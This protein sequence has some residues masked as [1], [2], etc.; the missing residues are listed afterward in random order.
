[1]INIQ[2]NKR[3][4]SNI[5]KQGRFI[6][7]QQYNLSYLST[8]NENKINLNHQT[9]QKLVDTLRH[10][11]KQ[12][13]LLDNVEPTNSS[14]LYNI[15]EE[16]SA[17]NSKSGLY[18]RQI[19]M[20]EEQFNEAADLY[21]KQVQQLMKIGKGT[22][23]KFVQR[24]LI[25]WFEPMVEVI[26]NE[27][28]RILNKEYGVDRSHY[29]PCLLLIKPQ[30]LAVIT[31]ETALNTI[32][33][34]GNQGI[35][36]TM[37]ANTIGSLVQ[38]EVN[39]DKLNK[40]RKKLQPWH[41]EQLKL[42]KE[43]KQI[44]TLAKKVQKIVTDEDWDPSLKI[45]VG[46]AL[47]SLLKD[48]A[49]TNTGT[50]AF[51][52][53]IPY[54]PKVKPGQSIKRQGLIKL[55]QDLFNELSDQH[56]LSYSLPRY[57]PMLVKPKLWD[58]KQSNT[59]CYFRLKSSL[60]RSF[61]RDQQIALKLANM[62]GVLE[63]LNYL[64]GTPWVINN[65]VLD[66]VLELW[67]KGENIGE[68]P[69]RD[70]I[71]LPK[72]SDCY[73]FPNEWESSYKNKYK[74]NNETE[75]ID[76]TKP[77]EKEFDEKYYKEMTRRVKLKNSELHSIRCDTQLK[78]WIAEKFRE[79]TMYFPYNLDFRGRAYPIPPNLNHLG[80]DLCRGLL[81]FEQKK[82]L[83]KDGLKWLQIHLC[84]L[85]GNNK[86][87]HQER[88]D[89]T[90]ENMS[91]VI[92]SVKNPVNGDKWWSTFEEPY[93]ALSTCIEI[94]NAIESGDP[95]SYMCSLPVH[96]DGSCNGLQ[97]YA[98]L[99][100][101]ELGAKAV[102]LISHDKPQDVYTSVLK[103]ILKKISSDINIPETNSR[104][105][106]EYEALSKK[107]KA[108]SSNKFYDR[109]EI[110]NGKYAR[111][112]DGLIDRKVIKQTVMTSVYGVTRV[113]AREQVLARLEEKFSSDENMIMTPEIERELYGA[114]RYIANLTLFSLDEMFE[115]AK[116][117]MDWLSH[118]AQ[119]VARNGQVM[120][121]IT[122]LGLPV[123]QP[124]RKTQ[125][126]TIKTIMQSV[127]LTVDGD[128][129]PVSSMKQRSAF[130][131]NFVHSLDATHMLLTSLQMKEKGITF[132]S[133]HDSYWT[134]PCDV[135]VMNASLRDCFVEL[136][137]QPILDKLRDSLVM[138][139]PDLIFPVL[140]SRGDLDINV[141]KKSS[142]FFH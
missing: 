59:S 97:H 132:A 9:T 91:K 126:H 52:H 138:R 48:S 8:L 62:N 14:D 16:I 36:L 140:P 89:W 54:I 127:T 92:D 1:M 110:L 104:T 23:F 12:V 21:S 41:I 2:Y 119:I 63:G 6:I 96:Q 142:Y 32:L 125:Q 93:Q 82:P 106:D 136:Y 108:K 134:H 65:Q 46:V 100:R 64:G 37:L 57:L 80:S 77:Q 135:P 22:G 40:Y 85:M 17:A 105:E 78:L 90:L 69:S 51:L 115:G 24:V 61:S 99:G 4:I 131:P 56:K 7:K 74:K 121:W 29:G 123:M 26:E 122:P 58:N 42:S 84:N 27:V 101:D 68:L 10:I 86:I 20:E 116:G 76:K 50:H 18:L 87:S 79:D 19:R 38:T 111:M 31:I 129:L 55:D 94:T 13:Q 137:S 66:I 53:S 114:A 5:L 28:A 71:P 109:E 118:C 15:N 128:A 45:K 103:I 107:D 60:M 70:N 73:R 130:P 83:G 98:A 95:E 39:I 81:L 113:G 30:K 35:P 11:P 67:K 47:V 133:V 112:V 34:T 49:R 43:P 3:N 25:D 72:Q 44:K 139:Y 124:Y 117:I 141:V 120:S 75:K 33:R 88:S 102:N